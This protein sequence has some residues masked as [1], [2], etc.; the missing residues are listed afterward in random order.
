MLGGAVAVSVEGW[1]PFCIVKFFT[2]YCFAIFTEPVFRP[3]KSTG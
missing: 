2:V 1:S 3:M